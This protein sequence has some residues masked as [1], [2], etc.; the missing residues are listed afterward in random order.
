MQRFRGRL[1]YWDS[2]LTW[3]TV[4]KP[5]SFDY[6]MH[7]VV[8]GVTSAGANL[9]DT[10]T[11]EHRNIGM[12]AAARRGGYGDPP[13]RSVR[14]EYRYSAGGGA[15]RGRLGIPVRMPV[16]YTPTGRPRIP[17]RGPSSTSLLFLSLVLF[18]TDPSLMAHHYLTQLA[19]PSVAAAQQKYFGGAQ[20]VSRDTTARD[21]LGPDESEF[22]MRRDSFYLASVA[23]SGWPY[24]QHRGGPVGFLRVLDPHRLAFADL[25]GNRQM[26]TTG[27]VA[28]DDRVSLFLMDYA[29]RER[30]KILGHARV[31]DA[32][33]DPELV[34]KIAKPENAKITERVVLIDV[35]SFDW[36]CPKYITPRY[37]LAEVEA[38]T[39]TLRDRIDTLETELHRVRGG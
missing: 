4:G 25:R 36:N 3:A 30:L 6:E 17:I 21:G 34:A 15:P 29:R 14:I 35:V 31:V 11:T 26:I 33:E 13:S 27:N 2:G 12:R 7:V 9:G 37:T 8:R 10:N 16:R 19:G 32:R 22:I 38:L 28:V 1:V 24:V 5:S 23:E 18:S 20:E 39:S